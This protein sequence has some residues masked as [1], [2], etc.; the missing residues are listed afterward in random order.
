[1]ASRNK[2]LNE[3]LTNDPLGRGYAGM[4]DQQATDDLNTFYRSTAAIDS[5]EVLNFL[6]M[7]NT[8]QT[9]GQDTQD[10]AIWQRML[11]VRALAQNAAVPGVPDSA[12]ANPWGSNSIGNI[13]EIRQIK[14]HQLVTYFTFVIQGDLD[15][16]LEDSNFQNYLS[17]AQQA[18]CMSVDQMN[19]LLGLGQ[20]KQSRG[21][22][23]DVGYPVLVGWV[24]S[25]RALTK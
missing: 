25:A 12:V 2:I 1:M 17:G 18:G 10:R 3:E 14:T 6:L 23:L 11:E 9:D 20:N 21:Q 7:Q 22:E 13:T 8:Y 19:A 4:D 24:T 5:G 15:V 16:Q